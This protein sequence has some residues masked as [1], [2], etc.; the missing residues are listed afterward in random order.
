MR[1]S[2]V[3]YDVNWRKF[4]KGSSMFF[5]CLDPDT[6]RRE[7]LEVTNRLRLPVTT[8]ITIEDGVRGLRVW[9]V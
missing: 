8:K 2:G 4:R 1:V 7:V 6:A 9:R 5:P 3:S